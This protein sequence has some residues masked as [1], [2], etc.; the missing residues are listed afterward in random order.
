MSLKNQKKTQKGVVQQL[1][2]S[3]N[4]F[5][6]AQSFDLPFVQKRPRFC[7]F[8]P[9]LCRAKAIW[10]VL[11]NLLASCALCSAP[12]DASRQCVSRAMKNPARWPGAD[13]ALDDTQFVADYC[14]PVQEEN[15]GTLRK[16]R[17][18]RRG[19][20]LTLTPGCRRSRTRSRGPLLGESAPAPCCALPKRRPRAV[21]AGHNGKSIR[22]WCPSNSRARR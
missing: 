9:P 7:V 22:G 20:G 2:I 21:P 18:A 19:E 15:S 16:V 11:P 10:L 14:T 8:A 4:P 1:G 13:A 17:Y 3:G 12:P 6:S 5:D